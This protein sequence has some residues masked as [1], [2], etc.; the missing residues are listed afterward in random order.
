MPK[1]SLGPGTLAYPTPVWVIGSYDSDNRPNV[2]TAAWAGICCGKPPCVTVSL[3]KPRYTYRNLLERQA[4]T[5]NIA[6]EQFA[7]QT[8]YFGIVSGKTTNKLADC[9]LTAVK[10]EKVDAPY[11]DEFPLVLECRVVQTVE[12]GIHTQ[13][14]GEIVDVKADD[15]ILGTGG[16]PDIEKLRPLIFGPQIRTY[17]GIGSFVGRAFSIGKEIK[18][19]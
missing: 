14:V 4:Y 8:D 19:N 3:Q 1:K 10:S 11:I 6:T 16:M 2:M 17:H 13:F 12:L 15:S 9:G 18:R 5:V 7:R